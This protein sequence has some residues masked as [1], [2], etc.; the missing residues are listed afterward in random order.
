MLSSAAALRACVWGLPA[1][2]YASTS[3]PS[4]TLLLPNAITAAPKFFSLRGTFQ[5]CFVQSAVAAAA[6]EPWSSVCG[7][8]QTPGESVLHANAQTTP[9]DV[10]VPQVGRA[11]WHC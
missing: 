11:P 4:R 1:A 9:P 2:L 7:Q 8:L 6:A 10:W 5:A 3:V